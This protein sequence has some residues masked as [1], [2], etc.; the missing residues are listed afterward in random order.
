MFT[1]LRK[2]ILL[3]IIIICIFPKVGTTRTIQCRVISISDGDTFQCLLKNNKRLK[4]RLEGIDAPE[5][6]QSFGK[7]S[8]QTLGNL[9]H[10]KQVRLAVSGYDHYHRALA[11]VYNQQ[12]Q[13]INLTMIKL[14]MAQTYQPYTKKQQYFIAETQAR[15]NKIGLWLEPNPLPPEQWRKIH[16]DKRKQ[17]IMNEEKR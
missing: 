15:Q 13:D 14:G 1:V 4:V 11:T 2:C 5:K 17:K 6:S 9:I 10:K 8:R 7:K 12:N 3:F 16:K